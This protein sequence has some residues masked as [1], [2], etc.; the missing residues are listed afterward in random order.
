LKHLRALCA[1]SSA[2]SY[3]TVEVGEVVVPGTTADTIV[4]CRHLC[5]PAMVNDDLTG[6]VVG[7]T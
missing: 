5:H 4:L 2:S 6:V 1:T 7:S 3:G